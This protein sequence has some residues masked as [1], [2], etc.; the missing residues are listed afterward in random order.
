MAPGAPPE[1]SKAKAIN[2]MLYGGRYQ[3]SKH[4]G[5]TMGMPFEGESTMGFDNAKKKFVSTWFDNM[6][7][8]MVMMEGPWNE[9]TKTLTLAGKC[10]D[11]MTGRDMV[12]KQTMQAVDNNNQQIE[13]FGPGPDGKEFKMM[14]IKLKRQ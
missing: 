14:E 9:A 11:P 4:I 8:G 1:I 2:S 12:L 3:L 10:V 6:G 13:M 5:S 7:T